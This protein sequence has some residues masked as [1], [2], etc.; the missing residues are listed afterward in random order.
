MGKLSKLKRKP[1][2]SLGELGENVRELV[3]LAYPDVNMGAVNRISLTAFIEALGNWDI[4]QFILS[5]Q[6]SNL[7][8]AILIAREWEIFR[9]GDDQ[10]RHIRAINGGQNDSEGGYEKSSGYYGKQSENKISS[11]TADLVKEIENLKIKLAESE[12]AKAQLQENSK[13]KRFK[14]TFC[15]KLGHT[16]SRCWQKHGKPNTKSVPEN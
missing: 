5:R 2:E 14:C 7:E 1:G 8:H 3:S 16:E 4:K 10:D 6:P 15:G 12:K 13:F 11:D 9:K